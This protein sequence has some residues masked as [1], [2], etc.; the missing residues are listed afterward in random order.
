MLLLAAAVIVALVTSIMAY[1]WMKKETAAKE[2]TSDTP[3][4]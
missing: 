1:N 4:L 2:A 3:L